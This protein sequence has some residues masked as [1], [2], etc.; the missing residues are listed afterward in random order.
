MVSSRSWAWGWV[1]VAIDNGE[2]DRE[3]RNG[4]SWWW[5]IPQ[6]FIG[7]RNVTSKMTGLCR[8]RAVNANAVSSNIG[9]AALNSIHYLLSR[10]IQRA[11]DSP[12][13]YASRNWSAREVS[14][15]LALNN[16][17]QYESG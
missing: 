12:D 9:N 11:S 1:V 17:G 3:Q 5:G 4:A 10:R 8:G 7:Y 13:G 14:D 6:G 15:P 2:G 16:V